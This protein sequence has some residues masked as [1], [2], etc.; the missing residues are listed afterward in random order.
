M[1]RTY[2]NLPWLD[3]AIEV[4]LKQPK[5]I[6]H[7]DT[8]VSAVRRWN[9]K[10]PKETIVRILNTYCSDAADF[11][12][13]KPDL[14]ERVAPNTFRLRSYPD[15]PDTRFATKQAERAKVKELLRE[16]GL[17]RVDCTMGS[18]TMILNLEIETRDRELMAQFLP[19]GKSIELGD[20]VRLESQGVVIRKGYDFPSVIELGVNI[21]L[22][23]VSGVVANLITNWLRSLRRSSIE[24]IRVNRTEIDL[25]DEG[26]AKKII[27]EQIEK[28]T[29]LD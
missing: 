8:I 28:T 6:A 13:R 12:K 29:R 15:R 23:I 27:T 20:N 14:F 4:M 5:G 19:Q 16:L 1:P 24:T 9:I 25:D 26:N 18:S 3:A 10:N 22:G 2:P 11:D 7:V 17:V 21:G